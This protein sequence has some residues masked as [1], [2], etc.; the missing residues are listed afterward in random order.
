MNKKEI[1]RKIEDAETEYMKEKEIAKAAY[2]VAPKY[3]GKGVD[4]AVRKMNERITKAR[5]K[6][7][8]ICAKYK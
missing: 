5:E 1:K 2:R 4:P 6:Y 8:S 7:V 3:Q